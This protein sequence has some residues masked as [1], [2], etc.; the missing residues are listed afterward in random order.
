MTTT[1]PDSVAIETSPTRRL[2]IRMRFAVAFLVGLLVALGVGAGALYAYDQQYLGRVLPGVRVGGVDLSG[3]DPATAAD[4]LRAEFASLGEGEVLLTGPAG[5]RTISYAEIGRGPDIEAMVA[6]ALAVG[7]DGTA[8]ERAIADARTALR[9]VVLTPRVTFDAD[10]L[11]ERI[12]GY[13]DDL[14][15]EPV[16]ASVSIVD[17]T[18]FV[19]APGADG[20]LADPATPLQAALG[21]L[22]K[23]DAPAS[24]T[25]EMPVRVV[26]PTVTTEEATQAKVDAERIA[27]PI[28]LT[29]GDEKQAIT[30]T[31]LRSWLTFG[32][33]ADG[34]YGVSIDTKDLP[35]VLAALSKKL[36]KAPVNASFKTTGGAITG[37]TASKAG[38]KV[39]R[40]ATRAQVQAV[41]DARGMGATTASIEP[42]VTVTEPALTTAEAKAARPKMRMISRWTTPFPISDRN[43][44]GANI[45][46]PARLINGYVVAP[47]ATFDFWDA[48]GP[49]TRAKG[50]KSGG[51]IINGR[52]EPQGAL[53]GG[54]CSCSTTLFNAALRAG[55]EM[56]ARRNHY[57]YIDRYPLGLDATVFISASGSKQTVSFTNDTDYPVLI[58]GYGFRKGGTG[59]VRFEIYSVP[60]GRK[61]TF[62]KPIVRN[63]RYATDTVQYTS[64]LAPGVRKRIEYPVD[65]KQVT[66]TR[67]VRDRSGKVLHSNT[68]FS[69]YARIT[70]ITLIGR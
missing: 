60:T 43:G 24:L 4:R 19:V 62:S 41:L 57:Y 23:L 37:V 64:S 34:G 13:A 69:N 58:R 32:A 59:Y 70:G 14:A 16:E 7:R 12:V 26:E 10:A 2:S 30:T 56:G 52:T 33:T 53:A 42:T 39:D 31:R 40:E 15:R 28:A 66:V 54:I 47:R 67:T 20:R 3:L 21:A 49:V 63:V 68:Y 1:T 29:V 38:Y 9:G 55:Y 18:K 65:G 48:V 22:G 50:Y 25:Y 6:D 8:V 27:A 61:T 51:A 11:A 35:G 36:D 46:I 45:W 44:F 17:K 5:G